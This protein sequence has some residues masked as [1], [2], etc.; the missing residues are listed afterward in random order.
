MNTEII[1]FM[2][3]AAA[4]LIMIIYYSKRR[5]RFSSAAFGMITGLAAL[6]LVNKYGG[7]IGAELP[8]NFF[9]ICGS[10]VLGVPFVA[11]LI[12]IKYI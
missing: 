6:V 8:L 10:A 3:C 1:F 2:T 11:G 4:V 5:K 12:I 7:I 9:N